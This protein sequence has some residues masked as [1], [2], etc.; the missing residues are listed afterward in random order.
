MAKLNGMQ[1]AAVVLGLGASLAAHANQPLFATGN[2]AE[3]QK[4]HAQSCQRCHDGMFHDRKGEQLYS[5]DFRKIKD[6]SS[7]RQ[8]NESCASQVGAGWFD[9]EIDHVSRY[10]NDNYYK[11]SAKR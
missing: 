11:F 5:R 6:A 7:L 4:L 9:E 1:W 2:A 10:L 8:R 3:G